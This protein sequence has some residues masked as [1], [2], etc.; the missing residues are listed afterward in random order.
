MDEPPF[1][2]RVREW[3]KAVSSSPEEIERILTEAAVDWA[4]RDLDTRTDQLGF[5]DGPLASAVSRTLA[6]QAALKALRTIGTAV[7]LE[8]AAEGEGSSVVDDRI[9]GRIPIPRTRTVPVLVIGQ[10]DAT[11]NRLSVLLGDDRAQVI[12]AS[13]KLTVVAGLAE[14]PLVVVIDATDPTALSVEQLVGFVDRGLPHA[15]WVLWGAGRDL[16]VALAPRLRTLKHPTLAIDDTD[17]LGPILDVV[18][19]RRPV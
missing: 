1:L 9:T 16:G 5:V 13:D 8:T 17:G 2:Q 18:L 10:S 12:H 19:S 6:P 7:A 3:L 4:G 11:T 15:F 14:H